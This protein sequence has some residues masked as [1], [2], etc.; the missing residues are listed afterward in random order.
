MI[1]SIL[2]MPDSVPQAKADGTNVDLVT[3]SKS[4]NVSFSQT[5][6]YQGRINLTKDLSLQI[7][8]AKMAD[9][10]TFTCMVVAGTDILEYPV[11][12]TIQSKYMLE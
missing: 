6:E 11:Q 9:Q 2:K 1:I 4:Q 12:V 7:S 10:K 3:K 8:Q 5:L